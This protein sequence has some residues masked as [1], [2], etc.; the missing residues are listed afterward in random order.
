MCHCWKELSSKMF[1]QV[2]G[3]ELP[4]NNSESVNSWR[5]V[6]WILESVVKSMLLVASSNT[7]IELRRRRAR[8]IAISCLWPCEKFVPPGDTFVS[9]VME[10]FNSTSVVATDKASESNVSSSP[11]IEGGLEGFRE[12][13]ALC[14]LDVRCD[15]WAL[16]EIKCT[17]C[18]TS[19]HSA[20][21]CSA[22]TNMRCWSCG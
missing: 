21:S 10:L 18:R 7:I 19:K 12:E 1:I 8:A 3:R 14:S 13:E 5:I 17:R 4:V 2:R 9:S 16:S 15:A 20:S 11:S 6:A 22:A